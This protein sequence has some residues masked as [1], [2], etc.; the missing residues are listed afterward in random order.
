MGNAVVH[1]EVA[2]ADDRL[3][4]T[5]YGELFGWRLRDLAG[6]GYTVIDTCAGHGIN[7]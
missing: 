4:A 7:G 6:G 2:A 1:F 5:F 3:L